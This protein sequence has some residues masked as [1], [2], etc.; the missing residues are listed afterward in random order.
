MIVCM[1]LR[2][3]VSFR[4]FALRHHGFLVSSE[5]NLAKLNQTRMGTVPDMVWSRD[6]IVVIPEK[7]LGQ[8]LFH[9]LFS[10]FRGKLKPIF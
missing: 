5:L 2:L 7:D 9:N 3:H 8:Q 10:I 1:Y 4:C 6:Y